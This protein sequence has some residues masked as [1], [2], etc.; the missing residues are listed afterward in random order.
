MGNCSSVGA[1]LRS[2]GTLTSGEAEIFSPRRWETSRVGCVQFA[3]SP[4]SG[5]FELPGYGSRRYRETGQWAL[6]WLDGWP[7][8]TVP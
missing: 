3:A 4:Q 5:N 6:G 8:A 7:D 2:E 1:Q